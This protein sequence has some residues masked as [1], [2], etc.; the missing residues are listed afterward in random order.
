VEYLGH[1]VG[2]YGAWVDPKKI[3]SIQDWPRPKTLKSL[4][5]FLGLMGYYR[6]FFLELW[7]NFISTHYSP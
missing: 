5:D 4:H 7:K 1:I 2:K 6:K 3:E